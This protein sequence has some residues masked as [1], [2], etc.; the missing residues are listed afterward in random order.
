MLDVVEHTALIHWP[1]FAVLT[2]GA[3]ERGGETE[4]DREEAMARTRYGEEW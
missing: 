2:V 4:E 1:H 3:L